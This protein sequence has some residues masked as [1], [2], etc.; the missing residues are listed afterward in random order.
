MERQKIAMSRNLVL[1]ISNAIRQT[2]FS[3]QQS[4]GPHPPSPS[5]PA[6]CSLLIGVL[7]SPTQETTQQVIPGS[8]PELTWLSTTTNH[9]F[10]S[11]TLFRVANSFLNE[12]NEP[13]SFK[14][15]S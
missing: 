11:G 10:I 1:F 12:T 6:F 8:S 14:V 3:F 2:F 5:T 15:V 9:A 7:D 4:Q 13:L